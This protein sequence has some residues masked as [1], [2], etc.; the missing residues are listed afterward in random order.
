MLGGMPGWTIELLAGEKLNRAFWIIM[1]MPVPVWLM[2]IV[3]PG[4][5]WVRH[6]A[7][8]FLFPVLMLIPLFYLYRELWLL[9]GIVWPGG[10]GYSEASNVVVHPIGFLILWCQ[11][12]TL[13]LFLGL[14]VFQDACK[15][16]LQIPGELIACWVLGPVGLLVYLLRLLIGR[17]FRGQ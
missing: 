9:G 1:L 5:R 2:V 14:V 10:I 13:H 15:R 6:I 4:Q 7:H 17:L 3:L 8:P 12:Q 16:G 11:V